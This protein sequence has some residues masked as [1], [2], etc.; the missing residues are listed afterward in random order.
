MA[1][2]EIK[3]NKVKLQTFFKWGIGNV[4]G[5]EVLVETSISYVNNIWCKVCARNKNVFRNNSAVKGATRIA[6][7]RF[8]NGTS[9][10]TNDAVID[11][12]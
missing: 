6:A 3:G 5:H 7:E 8:I 10:V 12:L 1:S 2:N 9:N 4:F 11:K